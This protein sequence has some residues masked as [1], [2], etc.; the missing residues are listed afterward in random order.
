MIFCIH[1]LECVRNETVVQVHCHLINWM[2][3][4][5]ALCS[6]VYSAIDKL[7]LCQAVV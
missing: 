6:V 3:I 7:K 1:S 2:S 4:G 5:C